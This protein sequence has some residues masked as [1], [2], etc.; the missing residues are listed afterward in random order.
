LAVE[1]DFPAGVQRVLGHDDGALVGDEPEPGSDNESAG[2]DPLSSESSTGRVVEPDSRLRLRDSRS[3]TV[4]Y[5]LGRRA[6]VR[7]RGVRCVEDVAATQ[8]LASKAELGESIPT[9]S[10]VEV[11]GA[12]RQRVER[13]GHTLPHRFVDA[14]VILVN[15]VILG[16]ILVP[17]TRSLPH[18]LDITFLLGSTGRLCALASP[19]ARWVIETLRFP[20]LET[21]SEELTVGPTL[22]FGG[23]FRR[24]R[25]PLGDVARTKIGAGGHRK[26]SREE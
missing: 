8:S 13:D 12:G 26:N 9:G 20:G 5:S 22:M 11:E 17:V 15:D 4:S 2:L 3:A 21:G 10:D 16:N 7:V 25:F 14:V 18:D 24:G 23:G 19:D 6:G 1:F